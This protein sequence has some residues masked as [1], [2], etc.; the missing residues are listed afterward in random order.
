MARKRYISTDISGDTKVAEL[1]DC[2]L[3]GTL[4]Y[5]WAIP[6]MDDWGRITGNYRE[7][8]SLVCPNLDL[9][10]EDIREAIDHIVK[11]KLWF[12]YEVDGKQCI[13]IMNQKSWFKHQ[14]YIAK[15][16]RLDDS[17]S[18]FPAPK[19]AEE[20][21]ET[22]KN[23]EKERETPQNASSFSLSVSSSLSSSVSKDTPITTT[24][25]HKDNPFS[26]FETHKFG[27]L[28]A[29]SRDFIGDTID[30]YTE[31]WVIHAIRVSLKSNVAVWNYVEK[32][33]KRWK[34]LNHSEP[35]TLEKEEPPPK[36]NVR[37]FDRNSSYSGKRSIPII[38]DGPK[39]EPMSDERREA[40]R[41]KAM[42]LDG[43]R[44]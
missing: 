26:L 19:N 13:S 1:S 42:M 9:K 23:A 21:R 4:L 27:K 37:N 39:A 2:S 28:D 6:H 35:W 41:Q 25:T 30:T 24:R 16:K 7:F 3:L 10:L 33:L 14:S 12:R 20:R 29:L 31:E 44:Q 15:D 8:K 32:I 18:P 17:S 40:M 38:T 36:N 34:L 11:V 22:P 5:T 43:S